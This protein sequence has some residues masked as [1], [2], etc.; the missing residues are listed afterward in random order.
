MNKYQEIL[1]RLY[2]RLAPKKKQDL[3]LYTDIKW[4]VD[5]IYEL[6]EHLDLLTNERNALNIFYLRYKD[7]I[8]DTEMDKKIQRARV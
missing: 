8:K 3:E 2:L 5:G 1:D 7:Q 4:L 6:Q